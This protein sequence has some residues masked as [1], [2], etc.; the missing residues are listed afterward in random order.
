MLWTCVVNIDYI[1]QAVFAQIVFAKKLQ[2]QTLIRE[3]L[4][5]R[6]SC[7]KSIKMLMKLLPCKRR[8]KMFNFEKGTK[9][10]HAVTLSYNNLGYDEFMF[11][12]LQ[13]SFS[14]WNLGPKWRV[15]TYIFKGIAN[16]GYNEYWPVSISQTFY[17]Q[18]FCTHVF[19]S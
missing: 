14:P 8:T 15:T 6:L 12:C 7:K 5:K 11:S 17:E 10:W 3:K 4:C 18:L 13:R 16:L 1:L 19:C 2:S 9:V